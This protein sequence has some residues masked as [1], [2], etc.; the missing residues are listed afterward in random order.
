MPFSL[1]LKVFFLRS[2]LQLFSSKITWTLTQWRIRIL[3]EISRV[4]FLKL[5]LLPTI[6]PSDFKRLINSFPKGIKTVHNS[7]SSH[8][9]LKSYFSVGWREW[10]EGRSNYVSNTLALVK[11]KVLTVKPKIIWKGEVWATTWL[12]IFNKCFEYHLKKRNHEVSNNSKCF[13]W[14]VIN[15]LQ[16][17]M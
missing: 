13:K 16:K 6:A 2:R 1:L 17:T 15:H 3:P 12:L 4:D 14:I 10:K 7:V 9:H 8:Y 5:L 11:L